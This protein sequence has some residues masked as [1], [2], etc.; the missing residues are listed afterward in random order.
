MCGTFESNLTSQDNENDQ[1]AIHRLNNLVKYIQEPF[2]MRPVPIG[3]SDRSGFLIGA[4]LYDEFFSNISAMATSIACERSS[5][6]I[7][8]LRVP[9]KIH[10]SSMI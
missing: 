3:R 6:H 9:K 5:R 10:K 8:W 1:E 4:N 7:K 2:G